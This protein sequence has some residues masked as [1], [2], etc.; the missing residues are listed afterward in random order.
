LPSCSKNTLKREEQEET[1]MSLSTP[2]TNTQ[3]VLEVESRKAKKQGFSAVL[4]VL[5]LML[6]SRVTR[7]DRTADRK[8]ER[9]KENEG[10]CSILFCTQQ[11]KRGEP[12][13]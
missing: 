11:E 3:S 8:K 9:Q 13:Q 6:K 5:L 10:A 4:F 1:R 12:R 7:T 2:A